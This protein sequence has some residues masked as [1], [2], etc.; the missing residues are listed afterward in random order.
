MRD[1]K[2]G[3]KPAK[4]QAMSAHVASLTNSFGPGQASFADVSGMMEHVDDVDGDEDD[5]EDDE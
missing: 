1:F 4:R 3:K 5:E 2:A